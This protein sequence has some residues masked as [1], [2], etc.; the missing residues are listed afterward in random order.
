VEGKYM[1]V[2]DVL[3]LAIAL[4]GAAC[5]SG[6]N[7]TTAPTISSTTT[8]A[9]T[10]EVFTGTVPVAGLDY[11]SFNAL[12]GP[13]TVTL[14][15]AGPPPTI[16]VGLGVGAPSDT[17]CVL[18]TQGTTSAQAG[19]TAQLSG[20]LSSSGPVCVEVFDIGNAGSPID[21]SVTVVHS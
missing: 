8:T 14:T 11:H 10:T 6:G 12:A 9:A 4:S 5:T 19:T 15:A 1:K 7:G 2:L 17:A 3:I 13:L 16:F 20:T 21:Y 18:Y